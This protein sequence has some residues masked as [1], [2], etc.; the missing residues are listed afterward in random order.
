MI[1]YI[2]PR[3]YPVTFGRRKVAEAGKR[4]TLRVARAESWTSPIHFIGE[5]QKPKLKGT[6]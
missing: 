1:H 2:C 5:K 3:T 4:R 6:C